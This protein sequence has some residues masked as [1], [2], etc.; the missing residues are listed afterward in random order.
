MLNNY[1]GQK[2]VRV[3]IHDQ[4]LMLIE[5]LKSAFNGNSE[6]SIVSRAAEFSD[7]KQ[8]I[9]ILAADIVLVD[10]ESGKRL[11]QVSQGGLVNYKV[12]LL[13]ENQVV[14]PVN[15]LIASGYCGCISLS[16]SVDNFAKALRI[17]W[18]GGLCFPVDREIASKKSD[19]K[20]VPDRF[21]I[22]SIQRDFHDTVLSER[23]TQVLRQ[24]AL[25]FPTKTIANQIDVSAKTVET[26]KLRAMK[27]LNLKDKN[28]IVS[29]AIKN[30]WLAY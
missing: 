25:G 4:R 30:G 15:E 10:A 8:N 3:Y 6:F 21:E 13:L 20:S 14:P 26:Y 12:I 5:G 22:N 11:S 19:E 27:K 2:R 9:E 28:S 24:T 29:F 23:E 16:S 7:L 17:V 1:Q 18:L